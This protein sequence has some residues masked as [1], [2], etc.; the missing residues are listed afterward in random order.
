MCDNLKDIRQDIFDIETVPKVLYVY[1]GDTFEL[2]LDLTISS[3]ELNSVVFNCDGLPEATPLT[4]LESTDISSK[5]HLVLNKTQT[6]I[7]APKSHNF[8]IMIVKTDGTELTLYKGIMA[9]NNRVYSNYS[10]NYYIAALLKQTVPTVS[11]NDYLIGT[12]WV[13]VLTGRV[14]F[15]TSVVNNE[16]KWI[17]YSEPIDKMNTRIDNLEQAV[18]EIDQKDTTVLQQAKDYADDRISEEITA[19]KVKQLYES[20]S[21]TNVF[22]DAEKAKLAGI[23]LGAEVN[24]VNPE[25]LVADNISFDGSETNFLADEADVEGAI[26]E[27]DTRVK[28]NADNVALKVDTSDIVDSLTSADVDKP[29]SANQGKVLK[30][31]VDLLDAR[32]DDL[33][34]EAARLDNEIVRVEQEVD[35]HIEDLDNPHGVTAEQVNTY[36]KVAIDTKDVDTLQAAKDYTDVLGADVLELQG[37]VEVVEDRIEAIEVGT[38]VVKKAEQDEDGNSIKDTYATVAYVDSKAGVVSVN[39]KAGVVELDATDVGALP[40]DTPIPAKLSDLDNDEGFVK[41]SDLETTLL[42]YVEKEAGK[43]LSTND[44]TTDEK[45]KLSSIDAGAQVNVIETVK[46]NGV[47]LPVSSK[48][49]D[50]TIPDVDLTDYYTKTEIDTMIG[51]IETL[52]EGI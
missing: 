27:L 43:G 37:K 48:A 19:E 15:L 39:G 38:T 4:L 26:K 9:V 25:D 32:V 40:D 33:E 41:E 21:D 23:E 16:A 11:D 6:L 46:V 20:N 36:N 47:A 10:N 42:N 51:D 2:D 5:W 8:T 13:N 45:N 17:E 30:D 52:L 18:S 28:A 22:T 29:L 1:R 34:L 35:A 14:Y 24:T 49:V 12:M 31:T 7:L 50:I 44:Y 3:S